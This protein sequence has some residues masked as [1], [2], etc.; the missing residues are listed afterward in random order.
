MEF[1]QNALR[2][3]PEYQTLQTAVQ[4][5]RTPVMATGLSRVHK[6]NIIDT[7]PAVLQRRALVLVADEGEAARVKDDL[8]LFGRESVIFPARDLCFQSIEGFSREF[9]HNRIGVLASL[10]KEECSTV[11]A[12]VDAVLTF[13]VPRDIL[14]HLL[15]TLKPGLQ[16]DMQTL[17]QKL[18][19]GG[20]SRCDMVEGEGQFSVRGGIVDVFIPGNENPVRVEFWDDEID[21]ICAFD[22][23]SQRRLDTLDAVTICPAKEVL[24]EDEAAFA[25][26]MTAFA[27][28][29]SAKRQKAKERIY[30]DAKNLSAGVSISNIDKYIPL[31]YT[32]PETLLDYLCDALIFLVD[33][34]KIQER[35]RSF[36]WQQHE[37]LKAYLEEGVLVKGL[38][39]HTLTQTEFVSQI[40][41]ADSLLLETFTATQA[42]FGIKELVNFRMQTIAP[43]G[44]LQKDLEEDVR[45]FLNR[46]YCVAVFAGT[47]RAAITLADELRKS[48][49]NASYHSTLPTPSPGAVLV[50]QGGLPA[51]IDYVDVK[52]AVLTHARANASKKQRKKHYTQ[53]S[54]AIG[55]LEELRKGDLV[56]HSV[57]GIGVFDGI[58]KIETSGIVKDYIKIKF[59]K[60]D[61]LYVPVTQLD[62]VSR[63]IGAGDAGTVKLNRLGSDQW[64]KTKTRVRHAVKDMAKELIAL[65]AKRMQVKGFAFSE[66]SDLQHDFEYHFPY[67]ETDDQLRCADEIKGD[68]EKPVPMERLLCGDVGFGKT[69]VALRA[70]F[71]CVC[72]GKQCAILVPT[73]I[74]AWQHYKTLLQR[75]EHFAVNC[76][77]L[78]RFRSASQQTQIKKALR[79]GEIDIIVGT[80]R[81]ISS[82]V[83]FKDLGLLIIDEEQRFGVAQKE[84]LKQLFPSVDVLTLSATPIPRTLNMAMSG[85]RDM[86]ILEEAPQDR[87]PV[88][89]YVLEHDRGVLLGAIHKELARGGQVYY[90]YNRVETIDRVAARLKIDLPD[91]NIAVAHGQMGEEELS[92]VWRALIDHEIDILVCTTIIE[93]GVDVPNVNTLIIE[94]A[95]RFGLAQLHQLR[96]RVGR[97]SR[98]AYAYLAFRRGKVLSDIA[99]KRLEAIREYT[100]FG[101]GFKIAMRDLEIRGA[102]NILGAKQ[103]GQMESVGYDMYLKLLSDAISEEKGEQIQPDAECLVDLQ[104]PAHIP[105]SYIESLSARLQIYRRIAGIQNDQDSEDVMDELIDRFGEPPAA[106]LGLIDIAL[107]RNRA[108][109]CG[110]YEISDK[111]GSMLFYFNDFTLEK[112]TRLVRGLKGRV[113]VSAGD[114]PYV[115][116]KSKAGQYPIDLLREVLDVY[117]QQESEQN[118][119]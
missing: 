40:E 19:F 67:E 5:G 1:L 88:Q 45:V 25:E 92:A 70:A 14:F 59:L 115:A 107:L 83:Q 74:L 80:H 85:L 102:G 78:S 101:S 47:E 116:V 81:L 71:K 105:E 21:T 86:S 109:K 51:G 24:F 42:G 66:D 111:T 62:L 76:E 79:R 65:Y 31:C 63:Y 22:V 26:K 60:D 99:T 93:T 33:P 48:G 34:G 11:I 37:D 46:N 91:A 43:W 82:D 44:G 119:G 10:L 73:T 39:R 28:S 7:L 114:K 53:N 13:T 27:D 72:D 95:D 84:K 89:T 108:A 50:A 3:V 106:V 118:K 23:V 16:M 113:M 30:N 98:R 96:G 2:G 90:I 68:M 20:Y 57:Y 94:D 100:E 15:L 32:Q 61:I 97:S 49:L 41:D 52:L 110:I 58:N 12:P 55:S 103:H 64:I 75:M 17:L 77:M 87:H 18:V 54:A 29:L 104:V 56:V 4:N 38:D 69:E 8:R 117:E 9:E 36:F 35:L 112:A 6:V